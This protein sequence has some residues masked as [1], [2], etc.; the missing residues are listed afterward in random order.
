MS[1]FFPSCTQQKIWQWVKDRRRRI[2]Q[3]KVWV[4][5]APSRIISEFFGKLVENYRKEGRRR[6]H[7]WMRKKG[8]GDSKYRRG[9]RTRENTKGVGPQ[10]G[11]YK[12]HK[13]QWRVIV[14]HK[15]WS[16]LE[17]RRREGEMDHI[18]T[19]EHRTKRVCQYDR[20]EGYGPPV[21]MTNLLCDLVDL[22]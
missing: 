9:D 2:P 13:A 11:P 6:G 21:C 10:G 16:I 19:C 3:C 15:H 14:T 12:P 22:G 8:R 5:Y 1:K 4:V 7:E 20:P 17:P 18:S